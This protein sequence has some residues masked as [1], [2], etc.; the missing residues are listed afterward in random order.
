MDNIKTLLILTVVII[1]KFKQLIVSAA[2]AVLITL[3]NKNCKTVFQ[4]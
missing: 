2:M 1:F 4:K 3:N